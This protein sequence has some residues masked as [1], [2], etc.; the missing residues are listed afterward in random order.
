MILY[1]SNSMSLS[2]DITCCHL[3][4]QMVPWSNAT[5]LD[6]DFEESEVELHLH[7][8]P[9]P[10]MHL[11]RTVHRSLKLLSF[12]S[13]LSISDSCNILQYLA[14]KWSNLLQIGGAVDFFKLEG[15]GLT[16][17]QKSSKSLNT[18][19]HSPPSPAPDSYC[20]KSVAPNW[21]KLCFLER[22]PRCICAYYF[23]T[24]FLLLV[25][26][27]VLLFQTSVFYIVLIYFLFG[28][29]GFERCAAI[30]HLQPCHSSVWKT[31]LWGSASPAQ[32]SLKDTS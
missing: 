19:E 3:E 1:V 22:C 7:T 30:E 15:D 21:T 6:Q 29:L 24:S 2:I 18:T 20:S 32:N 27:L 31:G 9:C 13:K 5:P 12:W 4:S 11:P 10:A 28:F 14:I 26:L 25:L 17:S 16:A 8:K 23:Q